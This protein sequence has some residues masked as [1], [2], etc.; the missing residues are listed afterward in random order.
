MD[1]NSWLKDGGYKSRKFWLCIIG[2]TLILLGALIGIKSSAFIPMYGEFVAGV[3]GCFS[4]Y[5]GTNIASRWSSSKNIKFK[6]EDEE[7]PSKDKEDLSD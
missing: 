4:I 6:K 3:L 7:L 5:A 1:K 2:F